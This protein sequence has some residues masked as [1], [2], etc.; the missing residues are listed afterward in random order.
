MDAARLMSWPPSTRMRSYR[1]SGSCARLSVMS[2]WQSDTPER[3]RATDSVMVL[4][5]IVA[6]LAPSP[7]VRHAVSS[8]T[9]GCDH[10]DCRLRIGTG[11]LLGGRS[12]RSSLSR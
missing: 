10:A 4:P 8:L 7:C 1:L 2:E 12:V 9:D 5:A 6:K 3:V 11:Q